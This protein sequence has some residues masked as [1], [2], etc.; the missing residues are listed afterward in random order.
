L[1]HSESH[2]ACIW[3]WGLAILLYTAAHWWNIIAWRHT[4]TFDLF[5]Y[6]YLLLVPCLFNLLAVLFFPQVGD[7][8]VIHLRE[9]YFG[10]RKWVFS[11]L[12]VI[13]LLDLVDSHLGGVFTEF[14]YVE[15]MPY[16][17]VTVGLAGLL[18]SAAVTR[19]S[20]Y[21]TIVLVASVALGFLLM[22]GSGG[23]SNW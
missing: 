12:A 10:T 19:S 22:L 2:S 9:Y 20:I 8:T 16:I 23:G 14:G 6:L 7:Q 21:H 4:T 15:S 17:G 5:I 13:V 11:T 3:T 18:F 1:Y